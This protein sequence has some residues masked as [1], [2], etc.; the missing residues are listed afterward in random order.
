MK[1]NSYLNLIKKMRPSGIVVG[2]V[3]GAV[4]VIAIQNINFS[5]KLAAGLLPG[6]NSTVCNLTEMPGSSTVNGILATEQEYNDAVNS[7]QQSHPN[8][9]PKVTWGGMIGKNHLIAIINSLGSN[10]TEV[11]FKF[12][13]NL[14]NGKTSIFFKGGSFNAVTGE[15]GTSNL[16]IRTGSA[17]DAFCPPRCN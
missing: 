15:P 12:I 10:A 1:N 2:I 3:I 11:N 17:S 4:S 8:N 13:T 14:S 6:V 7:Y 16:Y 9:D 5:K